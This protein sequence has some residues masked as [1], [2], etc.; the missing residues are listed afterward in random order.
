M[1]H[2]SRANLSLIDPARLIECC[3]SRRW[4][5][6]MQAGAPYAS[7]Q[8]LLAAADR[9][10]DALGWDD[11][12]E[13]FAAHARIGEPRAGDRQ[14]AAEQAGAADADPE[15]LAELRSGNAAYEARFGHVFLIRAAGLSAEQMLTALSERLE[16]SVEVELRNAAQQQRQITR[17]RLLGL[18]G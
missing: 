16:N 2:V 9:A 11:W 12:L 10:F 7:R 1:A 3:A 4:V 15:T 5:E 14:G 8:Q 17:L 18:T 6:L 13:A